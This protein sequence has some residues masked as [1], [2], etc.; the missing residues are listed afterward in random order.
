MI[1]Y[2]PPPTK[3][4]PAAPTQA[5]ASAFGLA[6]HPPPPTKFGSTQ[7]VQARRQTQLRANSAPLP[8]KIGRAGTVQR[9]SSE[10]TKL[11]K[12]VITDNF[13]LPSSL[14]VT[15]RKI[16]NGYDV[17]ILMEDYNT[18]Q[19]ADLHGT[20]EVETYAYIHTL[21]GRKF[22]S[23]RGVSY[24]LVE[25]FAK[26]ARNFGATRVFLTSAVNLESIEKTEKARATLASSSSS[27]SSSAASS[28][29]P[30]TMSGELAAAH[31]YGEL[32]WDV[33]TQ[34]GAATSF[35]HV[36]HLAATAARLATRK[37]WST[38]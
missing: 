22:P 8:P 34:A 3:F 4:G 1:K 2:P 17:N 29:P 33:R 26:V 35:V 6:G 13:Y 15:T 23:G 9:A 31:V 21:E 5:K 20:V 14:H 7:P 37:G 18:R 27:S 19:S 16:K 30:P 25:E 12:P 36:D 28:S 10:G 11:Y 38:M 32:G 24:A